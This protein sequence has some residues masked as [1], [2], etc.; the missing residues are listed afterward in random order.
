MKLRLLFLLLTFSLS[1]LAQ[2]KLVNVRGI[3]FNVYTKGLENRAANMPVIIFEN[4]MGVGLKTWDKVI[5][6]ISSFAPVVTYDRAGIGKS[7]KVYK[8]PEIRF[9][10]DNLHDILAQL[11][12]KPPYVLIGHSFGGVYIRSFAGFYP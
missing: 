2:E 5:D 12:V 9:V 8:M 1:S 11:A 7:D 6:Q 10:N 3:N 4:G